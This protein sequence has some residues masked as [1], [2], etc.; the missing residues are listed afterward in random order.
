MG[1]MEDRHEEGDI[2]GSKP[3]PLEKSEHKEEY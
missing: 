2:H 1:N 3:E